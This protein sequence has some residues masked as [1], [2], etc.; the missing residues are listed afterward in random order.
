MKCRVTVQISLDAENGY[1]AGHKIRSFL[2]AFQ[3]DESLASTSKDWK[4]NI[5]FAEELTED[6]IPTYKTK[7]II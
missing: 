5:P 1:E 7:P 2:N 6:N 3:Y 4:F